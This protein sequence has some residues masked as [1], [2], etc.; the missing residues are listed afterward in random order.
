MTIKDI[1]RMAGVS[2]ATV[3]YIINGIHSDRYSEATRRK[4]LQIVNLYD[5]RPSRLAKSFALSK[6]GNIIIVTEKCHSIYQKA[7]T[8]DFLRLLGQAFEGRGLNLIMRSQPEA[9]RVDTADA[10]ICL[11]MEEDKFRKLA[12]EN[13]VPMLAVDAKINDALFFQVFQDF[14]YVLAEGENKFGK[15]NFKIVLVDMYNRTLKR[16]IVGICNRILFIEG[17]DLNGLPSCNMVT[18]HASLHQTA[19]NMGIEMYLVPTS[20]QTRVDALMDCYTKAIER[21][22]GTIH[23]VRVK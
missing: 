21:V 23:T 14:E 7:E 1:A 19:A 2:V 13:Y 9:T 17:N 18:V 15:D 3:S 10:I 5:F 12:V 4:V 20:L 11:G 16:E 6:S 22:Q 8:Y